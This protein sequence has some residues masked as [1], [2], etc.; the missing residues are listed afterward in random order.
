MKR[1]SQPTDQKCGRREF[2]GSTLA[3]TSLL[4]LP[5][6]ISNLKFAISKGKSAPLMQSAAQAFVKSL[7]PDQRAKAIFA[8]EDEQ[9]FDWHFIPR[10]RKGIPVKELDPAQRQLANALL[11]A[12]LSQRG[13]TKATTIMSLDEV[14]REIE[15]G[16]GPVR[17]PELYYFTLFGQPQSKTPW[18]WRVEGHHLSLNFTILNA[19]HVASTPLFMGANPAEV[20]HGPRKGLRTLVAEE[21]A[22]RELVKSLDDKQ[23]AQAVVS[24]SAPNDILSGN[25]R[26][27]DPLP[28]AGL[29]AAQ[30]SQPQ[31]DVLMKLLQEYAA[32]MPADLAAARIEKLRSAGFGKI[33]FAWAGG[34]ERGQAHYYR[35]QGPTFLVEYDNIQNNANHIHTVWRDFNGDFG[36]DVL[37]LHHKNA[38]R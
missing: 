36:L 27:A 12:G 13:V 4:L 20:Q 25:S 19:Q 8:F 7:G 30:L 17:D 26:K 32:S 6:E 38:H 29:P 28:P 21:D 11:A 22:A 9:R 16:R 1:L 31:A 35:I 34:V 2:L 33:F 24:A 14:L 37:A 23:R 3:T 18:G 15:Q 10:S 5:S